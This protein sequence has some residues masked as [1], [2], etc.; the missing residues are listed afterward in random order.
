[1][2]RAPR[3]TPRERDQAAGDRF[4]YSRHP[5]IAAERSGVHDSWVV[6]A[7]HCRAAVE[8]AFPDTAAEIY[9]N[10]GK[11]GRRVFRDASAADSKPL[12]PRKAWVVGPRAE[13]LLIEKE[14]RDCEIVGVRFNAAVFTRCA[15]LHCL[16][17]R[18]S[19][20][21]ATFDDC[22]L[23]SGDQYRTA[24]TWKSDETLGVKPGEPIVLR[25]RMNHA[26]IYALD[27]E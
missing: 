9:F 23:I 18:C 22:K 15:F 25:F 14:T 11:L 8:A 21:D 27:F 20:F 2:Q 7:D 1:M 10:L 24:V 12:S 17:R 4:V 5:A 19:F 13:T 26:K 3:P 16:F 6:Q